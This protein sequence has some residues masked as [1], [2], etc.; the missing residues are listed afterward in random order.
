MI[1][2]SE[3]L[4]DEDKLLKPLFNVDSTSIIRGHKFELRKS[5]VKNKVCNH[6]FSIR[7]IND[8][9]SLP[10]VVVNAVSIDSFETILDKIWSD[11]KCDF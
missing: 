10:S 11:K 2:V 3:I 5:F 4:H 7:V 9:K 8:W 6:F 1:Q